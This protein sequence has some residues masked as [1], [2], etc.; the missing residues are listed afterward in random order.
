[1]AQRSE[2]LKKAKEINRFPETLRK[3]DELLTEFDSLLWLTVVQDA[4][5]Q[6]DGSITSRFHSGK[7]VTV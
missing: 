1:M 3:R 6:S 5:A 2:R 7:K 4:A